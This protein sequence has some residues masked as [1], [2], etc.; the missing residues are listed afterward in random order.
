MDDFKEWFK[1]FVMVLLGVV[2][3]AFVVPLIVTESV[4]LLFWVESL[5]HSASIYTDNP[6]FK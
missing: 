3:V 6:Y 1:I 2:I 5:L 4:H